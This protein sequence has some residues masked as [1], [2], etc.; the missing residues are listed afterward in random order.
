MKALFI[1]TS[2][3]DGEDGVGDY[4]KKLCVEC[5]TYG[6]SSFIVALKDKYVFEVQ[7]G[8]SENIPFWRIPAQISI[9]Q[10]EKKV[11]EIFDNIG[12]LDWVSLQFVHYGFNSKGIINR[13]IN[14]LTRLFKPYKVHIM[15]H[16]LWVG[17]ERQANIK[18][19]LLGKLQKFFILSL[20]KNIKPQAVQTSTPLYQ[21]ILGYYGVKAEIL[22]IFS[23][24]GFHNDIDFGTITSSWPF[25]NSRNDYFICC[26]FG[27]IYYK[28]W[29]MA[30]LFKLLANKGNEDGKKIMIISLGKIS[31]G[32]E[33]WRNLPSKYPELEFLTIGPQSEIFISNWLNN[34]VD[35]G[36]ITTPA[37][38]AGKS[39]SYM[40]FFERG[41][42]IFCKKN[43]LS[44]NFKISDD[45]IDKN[46]I[47]VSDNTS[48][49]TNTHKSVVPSQTK[50]TAQNFIKILN[51][52]F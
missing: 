14:P 20:I 21:K 5:K 40:A 4:V 30:D 33:F 15:M 34:Y 1:C 18:N 36:I 25:L 42:P 10:K 7:S 49:P 27:S 19:K 17:E 9:K 32:N 3:E 29:D 13:Y 47:Q 48:L 11:K 50:I 45:L 35:Y 51:D 28:S 52:N 6:V 8:V 31:Y 44:F 39:G 26:L 22:P 23:N 38:I 16:E 46:L 41:I 2:L 24:I 12:H 37:I 43:E